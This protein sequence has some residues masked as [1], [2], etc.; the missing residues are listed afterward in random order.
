MASIDAGR[1]DLSKTLLIACDQSYKANIEAVSVLAPQQDS[2][3]FGDLFPNTMPPNWSNL[4][5]SSWT[6][7]PSGRTDIPQTGFGATIYGKQ[8]ADGTNDFIVAMQGTRG[9]NIQDWGGNLIYGWD[10]WSNASIQGP[11][12]FLDRLDTLSNANAIH[13]TGQSLGGA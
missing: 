2:S 13:F 10:K 12:G 1:S 6:V 7:V 8:I 11:N 4:D 9:P 3:E 5:L